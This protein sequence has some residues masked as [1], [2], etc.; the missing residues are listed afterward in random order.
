M[1][2]YE[3][4]TCG[5]I[6]ILLEDSKV[7]PVCCQ[8]VMSEIIP[9]T[10]DGAKE[11]HVPIVIRKDNEITVQVGEII[12]PMEMDHYIK[13]IV[14]ETDK[15]KYI[16]YLEPGQEPVTKFCICDS[17]KVIAVY[18]YCSVHSLWVN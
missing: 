5:N 13:W 18:E 3:C 15:G 8:E 12:H 16:H 2:F 17:E 14:L 1:K 4:K 6:I 11:K 7:V 9:S 10:K